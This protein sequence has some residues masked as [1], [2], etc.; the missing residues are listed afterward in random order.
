M[1]FFL[2][3]LMDKEPRHYP[4]IKQVVAYK[5]GLYSGS[6]PQGTVGLQSIH[7][8]GVRT[9][10]SVDGAVPNAAGAKVLG[11]RYI[12]LP[13]KYDAPQRSRII[14]LAVATELGMQRGPTYIHCHQ[15]KHRSATAAAL[16]IIALDWSDPATML[17]RL[18]VS[19]TSIHYEGLWDAVA[20]AQVIDA[21]ERNAVLHHFQS[22]IHPSGMVESMIA[23]EAVIEDLNKIKNAGWIAPE[24]HPDL[25]PSAVASAL[26]ELF[27]H[28]QNDD[29]LHKYP[30]EFATQIQNAFG[31]TRDLEEAITE[32]NLNGDTISVAYEFVLQSCNE[33][34]H[35]YRK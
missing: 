3:T 28:L 13:M 9:I 20:N 14:E 16:A 30:T 8:L 22:A 29:A 5:S 24:N 11:M 25:V 21:T 1:Q 6:R 17:A 19:G 15:G 34:H 27:R 35:A 7:R 33:C 2:P 4:G 18:S 26:S 23:A 10:I 32:S 12:H 31:R